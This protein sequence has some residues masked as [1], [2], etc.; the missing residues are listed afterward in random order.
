VGS[1][2]IAEVLFLVYSI[3]V[4]F[5][6]RKFSPVPFF[7]QH[8]GPTYGGGAGGAAAIVVC[9]S[10][11]ILKRSMHHRQKEFREELWSSKPGCAYP[12][13]SSPPLSFAIPQPDS[14]VALSWRAVR[15]FV[16]RIYE[17]FGAPLA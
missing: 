5:I 3:V 6:R 11:L 4:Y 10:R 8:T 12:N 15:G 16:T 14:S 2:L 1:S 13:R 9:Q 7:I 17:P